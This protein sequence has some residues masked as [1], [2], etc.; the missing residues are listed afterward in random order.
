LILLAATMA[1]K[2]LHYN[3]IAK[4]V[5]E[6]VLMVGL[7]LLLSA[8]FPTLGGLA[9]VPVTAGIATLGVAVWAFGR[10][11]PLREVARALRRERSE[12]KVIRFALPLG[13][14]DLV[15]ILT[16]RLGSFILVAFSS[17]SERAIFNSC[18]LLAASVSFVRGAFD[19]VL[20][21]VAAEAWAQRDYARLATN[22]QRQSRLVLLFAVPLASL[23]IVGGPA[24]LSIYGPG[25]VGGHRTL[26]WLALGHV[27]NASLG[28][29]GWI[30]MASE[31]S[32][33]ILINNL[34][35]LAVNAVLCLLL[36]RPF[37]IEGAAIATTLTIAFLQVLQIVET[38][39]ITRVTPFS[40][41]M[42]RLALLGAG[43]IGAELLALR[44]LGG[45]SIVRTA[46]VLAAGT[47]IYF[48]AARQWGGVREG[49]KPAGAS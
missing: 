42:M 9:L 40:S 32:R 11:F 23:F 43:T 21:P 28:L 13:L 35:T 34:I 12:S 26:A 3:L 18:V 44:L 36:V 37:G 33:I 41:G 7:V 17:V 38:W 22:L 15:N 4:G 10:V 29:T 5:T 25:F 46:A 6:P 30:L 8:T 45:T 1:T 27:L 20:A 19:T 16:Y 47:G 14:S 2:V 48:L 24:V 31:S 49:R 39:R